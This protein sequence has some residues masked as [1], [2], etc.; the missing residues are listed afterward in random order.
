MAKKGG[1]PV[2]RKNPDPKNEPPITEAAAKAELLI[3]GL[4]NRLAECA[5]DVRAEPGENLE[6]ELERYFAMETRK[7][8]TALAPLE[9]IRK[10]VV[11]GVAEKVLNGWEWSQGGR[12]APLENE[13]IERLVERVFERLTETHGELPERPTRTLAAPSKSP[14]RQVPAA[15]YRA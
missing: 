7:Q 15:P 4:Q 1:L 2:P 9:Q 5:G 8:V 12:V 6:W 13:V 3:R 11:E 14:V 10:R